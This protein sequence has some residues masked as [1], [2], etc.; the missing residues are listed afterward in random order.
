MK[1]RLASLHALSLVVLFCA[2]FD[3]SAFFNPT[4]GRFASRD[5][6]EETG[7]AAIYAFCANDSIYR[8]D[9]LGLAFGNPVPGAVTVGGM[10]YESEGYR[11]TDF[12]LTTWVYGDES[13]RKNSLDAWFW[14]IS[15]PWNSQVCN[16]GELSP[17]SGDK[18]AY[19]SHVTSFVK[20]T[21]F[22]KG[23]CCVRILFDCKVTFSASYWGSVMPRR[24]RIVPGNNSHILNHGMNG[25]MNSSETRRPDG[26]YAGQM[27][28]TVSHAEEKEIRP[29]TNLEVYHAYVPIN[30]ETRGRFSGGFSERM[31]ASCTTSFKG[32]CK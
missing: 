8:V 18:P 24:G 28:F 7:G 26:T 19:P 14:G 22:N 1:A 23:P 9:A 17:P 21:A 11:F 15:M 25:A 16:S 29:N 12:R 20:G 30:L 31:N 32:L 27:S 4:V 3:A 6:I 13:G 5:P 10:E 2:V